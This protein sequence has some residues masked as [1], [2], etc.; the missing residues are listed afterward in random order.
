MMSSRIDVIDFGQRAE[1]ELVTEQ[2]DECQ[3]LLGLQRLEHVADFGL[4]K[5]LDFMAQ[6]KRIAVGDRCAD[7]RQE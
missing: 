7:M 3:P 6:G 5:I 1:I 2:F 4:V